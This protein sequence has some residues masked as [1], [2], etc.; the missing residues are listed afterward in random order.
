MY[1]NI[2]IQIFSMNIKYIEDD[3]KREKVNEA[4]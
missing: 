3:Y 2:Y 4:I 1:I